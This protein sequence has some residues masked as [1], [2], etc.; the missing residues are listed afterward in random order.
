LK[1]VNQARDFAGG[2]LELFLRQPLLTLGERLPRKEIAE[3]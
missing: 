2:C 1:E 3:D